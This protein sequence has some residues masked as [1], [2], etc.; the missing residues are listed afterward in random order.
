MSAVDEI[1]QPQLCGFN[2]LSTVAN[3]A[4]CGEKDNM[5]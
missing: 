3:D 4:L 2:A 1:T 5:V